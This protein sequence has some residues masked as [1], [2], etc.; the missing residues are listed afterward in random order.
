MARQEISQWKH[1]DYII[2]T[3]SIE[4]DLKRMQAIM[5][6]EKMRQTRVRM[7]HYE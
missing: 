3:D 4:S 1:F 2:L 5:T 7:P 6:A